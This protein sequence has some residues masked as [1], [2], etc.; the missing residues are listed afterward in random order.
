MILKN[1]DSLQPQLD[2]L[3]SLLKSNPDKSNLIEREIKNIKSG[4]KGEK[5]SAYEMYVNFKDSDNHIVIHDL[6]V[7]IN[8]LVAQIDHLVINR[9]LQVFVCESKRFFEGISINDQGEFSAFY[10]NKPYGIPSPLEQNKKHIKILDQLFRS[11]EVKIPTRLGIKM[12]PTFESVI[13]ISKNARISRPKSK[14]KSL[15]CLMKNDMFDKYYSDTYE[16]SNPLLMAKL[17]SQKSLKLFAQ[18]IVRE[19]K[20]IQFNWKAK[21]GITESSNAPTSPVTVKKENNSVLI[22]ETPLCHSCSAEVPAKVVK[23]CLSDKKFNGVT[24]CRDC[25]KNYLNNESSAESIKKKLSCYSCQSPV[26][27]VV[28]KFCWNN[29]KFN[30]EAYCRDCQKEIN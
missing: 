27:F 29:K 10:K 8:G 1:S 13:L 2:E 18:A 7:E 30:G 20:P 14:D 19:H 24:Y 12:F 17:V 23:Y 26:P 3:E 11:G 28:A 21:F 5:E 22:K 15:N 4:I 25:Q 16:H 9:Q 6:R